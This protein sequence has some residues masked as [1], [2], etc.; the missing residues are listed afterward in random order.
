MCIRDTVFGL[1]CSENIVL[2][3]CSKSKSKPDNP[4]K[5]RSPILQEYPQTR[6]KHTSDDSETSFEFNVQSP[7]KIDV[8]EK[9]A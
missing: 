4:R 9:E 1:L 3:C 2:G 7:E 6:C 5:P 8:L